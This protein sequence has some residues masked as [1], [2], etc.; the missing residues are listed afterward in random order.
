MALNLQTAE[1]ILKSDSRIR[2]I[3]DQQYELSFES[4]LGLQIAINRRNSTKSIRI[5]IQ[6]TIEPQNLDLS[7][8][9]EI[10]SYPA[11]KPRSHLSASKLTGPYKGRSGNDCWYIKLNEE[12]DLRKVISVYLN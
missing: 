12:S 4:K 1:N 8:S 2:V 3:Y 10:F 9:A 5:W 7:S 6:N 11:S